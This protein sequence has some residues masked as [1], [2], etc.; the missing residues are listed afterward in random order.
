MV[1]HGDENE[2]SQRVEQASK[3]ES[4]VEG[5]RRSEMANFSDEQEGRTKL[6]NDC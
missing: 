3:T 2:R 5:E 6:G 1:S 4:L